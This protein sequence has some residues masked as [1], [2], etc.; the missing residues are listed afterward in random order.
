MLIEFIS[1]C[2]HIFDNSCRLHQFWYTYICLFFITFR[3]QSLWVSLYKTVC[4]HFCIEPLVSVIDN[5]LKQHFKPW[6]FAPHSE[7]INKKSKLFD[8]IWFEQ[9]I[10]RLNKPIST[11]SAK[12][13]WVS[14]FSLLRMIKLI[15]LRAVN[16]T[17]TPETS[18]IRHCT[19]SFS[20]VSLHS[21][22]KAGTS[23]RLSRCSGD[24]VY[25]DMSFDSKS[26]DINLNLLL[27]VRC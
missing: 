22:T 11:C 2:L 17:T 16:K 12:T 13:L 24:R 27:Q 18:L 10:L 4:D 9:K 3:K 8:T 5:D 6:I 15:V 7:E 14:S 25:V 19:S 20:H 21:E 26:F 1:F 23:G